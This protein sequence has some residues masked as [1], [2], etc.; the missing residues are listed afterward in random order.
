MLADSSGK[1][2]N[3]I[4]GMMAQIGA[5]NIEIA[6]KLGNIRSGKGA[7]PKEGSGKKGGSEK[8]PDYMEG[9]KD[10]KDIYHDI[11][12]VLSQIST[13]LDKLD[14]Q[15][16]KLFGQDLID[17]LNKQLGF[18]NKQIDATGEKINIARGEASLLKTQLLAAGV[19]FN[20]DGTIS[21]YAQAYN[22]Q[23]NYVNSLIAQYDNMSAEAQE[24][25]KDTVEQ[26]KKDFDTFVKNIDRYDEIIT[27]MIPDLEADIQAATD[28]KIDLQIEK[29]DMEIEIRLDL[30]EA[31]RD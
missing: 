14:K 1:A 9:L 28:K 25:F 8:E 27:D 24:G 19:S 2:A 10:E 3:D 30:A 21:N 11:N 26:A 29:F 12:I 23:L 15:R 7:N 16:K 4:E 13:E 17:N 6:D 22:S 20:P 18:L 5:S 31:E